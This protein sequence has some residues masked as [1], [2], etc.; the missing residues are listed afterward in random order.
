MHTITPSLQAAKKLTDYNLIPVFTQI[1]ADLETPVSAFLKIREGQHSFLL[2]SVEG[3]EHLA[4]YSFLGTQP[5]EVLVQNGKDPLIDVQNHL[6]SVK[7]FKA[8]ELPSSFVGGYV[9]YIA[10]DCVKYYEQTV[11]IP[12]ESGNLDLPESILLYCPNVVIFDHV[13]HVIRIVAHIDLR[14]HGATIDQEY[15]RCLMDIEEVIN[16]LKKPLNYSNGSSEVYSESNYNESLPVDDKVQFESFVES[17]K[18]N[19]RSGDIIQA[20]PSRVSIRV[21]WVEVNIFLESRKKFKSARL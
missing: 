2:E 5:K 4:R 17:L 10:Y 9:G 15:A 14:S 3:G 12:S 18:H 11:N 20:V 8:T 13:Q 19:I 1:S 7:Y 16:K 6:D 21:F